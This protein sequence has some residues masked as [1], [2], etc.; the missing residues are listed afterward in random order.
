MNIDEDALELEVGSNN[1]TNIIQ[2]GLANDNLFILFHFPSR[3]TQGK[4]PLVD[5]FQSHCR[6]PTLAKCGGEAQHL[7][8]LG[9]GVLCLEFQMFRIQHQ[10]PKHLALG[11]S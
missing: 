11:C 8:K 7:E 10:G 3:K 5:Y 2:Q 1:F 6:N 9:F 4:E